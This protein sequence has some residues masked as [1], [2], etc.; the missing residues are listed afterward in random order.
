MGGSCWGNGFN[1][2]WKSVSSINCD[3]AI[4]SFGAYADRWIYTSTCICIFYNTHLYG[5][6]TL[7]GW[8]MVLFNIFWLIIEC[9]RYDLSYK[10]LSG[11][12]WPINPGW[13]VFTG[14]H[15]ECLSCDTPSDPNTMPPLIQSHDGMTRSPSTRSQT[16]NKHTET[17]CLSLCLSRP[18]F[19]KKGRM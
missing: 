19:T 17:E 16:A 10:L 8:L 3:F 2:T 6:L 4:R 12:N 9:Y 13:K 14:S 7:D 18:V 5:E 1:L 15:P 11:R